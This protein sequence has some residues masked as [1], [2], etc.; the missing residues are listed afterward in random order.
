MH[1]P[2]YYQVKC[3]DQEQVAALEERANRGLYLRLTDEEVAAA[4]RQMP[5]PL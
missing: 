2:G 1:E 3:C 4:R 5:P